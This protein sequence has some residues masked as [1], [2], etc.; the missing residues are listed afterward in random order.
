MNQ[1]VASLAWAV[2]FQEVAA[3]VQTGGPSVD[4]GDLTKPKACGDEPAGAGAPL[5]EPKSSDEPKSHTPESSREFPSEP[6]PFRGPQDQTRVV[7]LPVDPYLVHV[8]W[9]LSPRDLEEA[10]RRVREQGRQALAVLKF[11]DVTQIN[12]DGTNAHSS[13]EISI[14]LGARN[15]YVHLWS[16]EKSYCVDLGF[17]TED[18]GFLSIARS[19]VA[20]TPRAWPSVRVGERYTSLEPDHQRIESVPPPTQHAE[21]PPMSA[22]QPAEDGEEQS[23]IEGA[24][25]AREKAT[26]QKPSVV[27]APETAHVAENSIPEEKS[28]TGHGHELA[29]LSDWPEILLRRL[30]QLYSSRSWRESASKPEALLPRGAEAPS[31]EGS[32][33]DLAEMSEEKFIAGVSSR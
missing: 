32:G 4:R 14:E 33:R 6:E 20:Q 26:S 16:P 18:G 3:S 11:Y 15:W 1:S 28:W 17:R 8:Y 2:Q 24:E 7:L 5:G 27:P 25:V 21:R 13:F 31:Q 30:A 22:P 9:E 19:N 10:E 29:R 12:F 23:H